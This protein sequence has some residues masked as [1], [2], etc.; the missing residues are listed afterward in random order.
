MH[1]ETL[2]MVAC[3]DIAARF[4][5]GLDARRW[6]R[7]GVRRR[8][9]ALPAGFEG[10]AGDVTQPRTLARLAEL[11]PAVLLFTPTPTE[12]SVAGYPAGFAAAARN[13]VAAL[14]GHRPR[15]AMLVSSTRVYAEATGAWV[16]EDAPLNATDA[17]AAAIIAAERTFLDAIPGA[18]VLRAGGL[19]GDGPGYLLRRV[20]AGQL[21]PA[22]PLRF[23]NRIHR[24]DVAG[25][26]HWLLG[27][28][29]PSRIYN[30]V[31]DAPVP[32]QEV[33]AWLCAELGRP[34]TPAAQDTAPVRGHKRVSNRRLRGE[35]C[36][37][38]YPDYRAGY[39]QV[40]RE[41]ARSQGQD[42]FDFH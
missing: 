37:L 31:D 10:M 8:I 24:D 4:G 15:L 32:Q 1:E 12:R 38:R 21:T 19:Y 23:S 14:A 30:L 17:A 42:G 22:S 16:D 3:G 26:M 7:V 35:G 41:H 13:V 6:R 9:D 29:R 33:E 27:R 34:Y 5:A 36:R 25:C 20:A 39:A 28:D 2:L 11:R 18:V 40:L